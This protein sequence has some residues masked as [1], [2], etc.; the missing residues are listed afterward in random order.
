MLLRLLRDRVTTSHSYFWL[1][2]LS[3]H[4]FCTTNSPVV[5]LRS[6]QFFECRFCK[7]RVDFDLGR[8]PFSEIR[9]VFGSSQTCISAAGK[10]YCVHGVHS[11][12][13]QS[14]RYLQDKDICERSVKANLLQKIFST[15][16]LEI[17]S[18]KSFDLHLRCFCRKYES[19]ESCDSSP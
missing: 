18:K 2:W 5:S 10:L 4:S 15:I 14:K 3:L 11:Q 1:F 7:Q 13:R 19:G 17:C 9:K 16:V 6:M 12:N 8:R